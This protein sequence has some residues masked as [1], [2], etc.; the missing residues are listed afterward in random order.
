LTRAART[1]ASRRASRLAALA[2]ALL[3]PASGQASQLPRIV[4]LNP[5]VDA[6]LI[7][8]AAEEQIVAISYYSQDPDA[9]SIPLEI[10]KRFRVTSHTAEEVVALAP[11]H[12]IAGPHVSLST[13]HALER[14]NV[15]LTQFAVAETVAQS[16]EQ[17][18]AIA[19]IAGAPARGEALVA[20]IERAL[21]GARPRDAELLPAL[22]W[23][24]QGL[25]PGAGT[26]A[27]E[28]LE[29]TGFRNSSAEYGLGKWGV[30]PIEYLLA[31]PPALVLSVGVGEGGRDRMLGHPAVRELATRVAF[32][33][34]SF[35][36]LSC[37]GPTIVEAVARLASVRRELEP[38]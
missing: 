20:E 3:M 22:I 33:T 7:R 19:A 10:A 29:R 12:V 4:S 23:Q 2:G 9:T 16:E 36:L 34:Y 17:I 8:V 6:V 32:R 26:L 15:R 1:F 37:G 18:R 11:D 31:N 21:D 24:G 13:I 27:D 38:R 35:R 14:M 5:C 30:L 28:L 25:V